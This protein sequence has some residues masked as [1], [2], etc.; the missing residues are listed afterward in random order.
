MRER[1]REREERQTIDSE[2]QER[3]RET[4]RREREG[5]HVICSSS[6]SCT[7]VDAPERTT[8]L[9]EFTGTHVYV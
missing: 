8:Y 1:E 3:E 9:Q 4:E 2:R 5:W 7:S 6:A